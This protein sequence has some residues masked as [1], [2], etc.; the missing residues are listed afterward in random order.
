MRYS[1][2]P[3]AAF[4]CGVCQVHGFVGPSETR[5]INSRTTTRNPSQ[6]CALLPPFIIGPMIKKMREE[7]DKKN[8][9]MASPTEAANEAP[10]LRVGK[11][12]WRWPQAWPY[13]K[14]FFLPNKEAEAQKRKSQ[15]EGMA[16]M[17]SG[18]AQAPGADEKAVS[19]EDKFDPVT[20]WQE[21]TQTFELDQEAIENLKSHFQFYLKDE[22]SILELGAGKDSY[23]PNSIKPI[24]HV[25]VSLE[26]K[27][28]DQNPS[29]T[30]KLVVDLNKVEDDGDVDSE[31]L[32]K[33]GTEP[34]DAVIMTNTVE[35]LVSPR[36]V[37]RSAWHL[38][39]PGGIMMVAFSAKEATKSFY[40]DAQTEA[41]RAYNDDQHMWITGSFFQFSAGDG[42]TDLIGFDISPESAKKI[43]R[44][45]ANPLANIVKQGKDNNIFVVQAYKAYQ[46]DS[47]DPSSLED[48]INSLTWMLPTLEARDKKLV[49]P[50]LARNYELSVNDEIKKAI[51]QNVA[52]LPIVYEPLVKMDQFAFTFSMQAQLAA[53]LISDPGFD[54]N[55][56]QMTALRQGLGLLK[57]SPEFWAP[58]GE[59]TNALDLEAKVNLL[60]YI[61]PRFGTGRQEQE[62]ALKAFVTALKPTYAVVRSKCHDLSESD[63]QLLGTELLAAEILTPGVAT[64]EEFALWLSAMSA[65]EMREILDIR[66]SFPQMAKSELNDYRQAIAQQQQQ[67]EEYT[68]KMKEQI[69]EAK[70]NRKIFLNPKTQKM[71]VYKS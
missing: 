28:M 55:D 1:S 33:L 51:E 2:I 61:V 23:L 62:D 66:K 64:R 59:Y 35:Y 57:P 47:I 17:L 70:K 53:D 8:E 22:L 36:E 32:R 9:P 46:S 37:F 45:G 20:F 4:V 69:K 29:L 19:D 39:K 56:E 30:E 5:A 31:E 12:A 65:D 15:L 16:S 7:N 68:V 11:G 43:D 58:V 34:F 44:G 14:Q 13:A 3:I 67:R 38:L 26:P 27:A 41:W 40:T 42:W 52:L 49:V 10:G 25:G 18:V 60:A 24:R 21:T 50:R 48:S 71:E 6:L 54:G 63:I